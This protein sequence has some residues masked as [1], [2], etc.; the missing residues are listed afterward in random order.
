MKLDKWKRG[1]EEENR[2]KVS[3][4]RKLNKDEKRKINKICE[5]RNR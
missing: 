4:E 5:K 1:K 2:G 3:E